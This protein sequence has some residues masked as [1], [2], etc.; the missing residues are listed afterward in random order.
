MYLQGLNVPAPPEADEPV[1]MTPTAEPQ[2]AADP[3][4][5]P[6]GA[7]V[8]PA[9][10]APAVEPQFTAD[11]A[12]N[13]FGADDVPAAVH[14]APLSAD[15]QHMQRLREFFSVYKP[16]NVSRVGELYAKL[17]AQAWNALEMKY[18][19][20]TAQFTQVCCAITCVYIPRPREVTI[21]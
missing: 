12:S 16:E 6:F 21:P 10:L 8:V 4:S 19:G 5:N 14:P 13:P 15:D 18:P 3:E 9:A 20:C 1:V 11:P 17:G 7:D 2:F